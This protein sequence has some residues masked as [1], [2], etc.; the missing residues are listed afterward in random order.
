MS[1][2]IKNIRP[3]L[4]KMTASVSV[5]KINLLQELINDLSLNVQCTPSETM[6]LGLN[7]N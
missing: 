1:F 4:I 7:K 5:E 2:T 3:L 6:L